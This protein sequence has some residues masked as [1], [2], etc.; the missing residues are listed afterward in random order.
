MTRHTHTTD[1]TGFDYMANKGVEEQ[2]RDTLGIL[3][4]VAIMA[5]ITVSQYLG[6]L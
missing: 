1:E 2:D 6:L 4:A 5:V 3:F